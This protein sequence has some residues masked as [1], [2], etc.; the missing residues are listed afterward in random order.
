[1]ILSEF[2]KLLMEDYSLYIYTLTCKFVFKISNKEKCLLIFL[3]D[4][5]YVISNYMLQI[6]SKGLWRHYY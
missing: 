4:N 5:G 1:M 2:E 6:Y 3:W